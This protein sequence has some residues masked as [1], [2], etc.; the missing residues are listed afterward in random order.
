MLTNATQRWC[1][2]LPR[3]RPAGE[4]IDPRRYEVA[5]I[6]DDTT[7][8]AFVRAHHYSGSY[9][10]ARFRI[11]LYG[12]VG[13]LEGV[14]VFSMPANE[15]ALAVLPGE[16]LSRVELGR[17]VLI[18]AVPGNGES[19]FLARCFEILRPSMASQYT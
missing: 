13:A 16:R 9:P 12:N 14:A 2:D 19:W 7:A 6:A 10:A 15:A 8:R 4:R 5:P 11:G 3:Y 18:D 17:F 1:H